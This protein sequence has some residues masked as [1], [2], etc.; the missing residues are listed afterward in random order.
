MHEF[1]GELERV[2]VAKRVIENMY[3]FQSLG[4]ELEHGALL[5]FC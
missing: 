5:A 3:G 2:G 4:V 1:F